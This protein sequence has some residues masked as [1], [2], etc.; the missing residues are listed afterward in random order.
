MAKSRALLNEILCDILGSK[1]CYYDP[2]ATIRMK[3]PCIIYE[4]ETR[5]TLHADDIRYKSEKRYSVTII[6][7]HEDSEICERLFSD[8]RLKFLSEDRSYVSDGLHHYVFTV[9][10]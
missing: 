6:D 3:Y 8:E 4:F 9:F 7:E 2:P 1:N 5:K 10:W